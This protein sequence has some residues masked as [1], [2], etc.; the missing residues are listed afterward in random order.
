MD[1]PVFRMLFDGAVNFL[2]VLENAFDEPVS[3]EADGGFFGGR[4]FAGNVSFSG[5]RLG[6]DG[7]LRSPKPIQSLFQIRQGVEVVLEQKLNRFFS[8]FSAGTHWLVFANRFERQAMK[9]RTIF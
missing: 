3:E 4:F 2:Q 6:L 5:R 1:V 9:K 8:G 7:S